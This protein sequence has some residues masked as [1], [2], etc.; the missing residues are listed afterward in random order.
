MVGRLFSE[1]TRVLER[2][3]RSFGVLLPMSN[4]NFML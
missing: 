3:G 1:L 4:A 2:L